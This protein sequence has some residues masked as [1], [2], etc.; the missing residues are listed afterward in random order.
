MAWR[1]IAAAALV[2]T[3]RQSVSL[4]PA[5]TPLGDALAP[6]EGRDPEA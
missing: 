1:E 3:E 6:L 4:P 5:G 2:G